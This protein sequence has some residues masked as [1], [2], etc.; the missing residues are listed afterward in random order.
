MGKY[1]LVLK[2]VRFISDNVGVV[3][4]VVEPGVIIL[5]ASM[6]AVSDGG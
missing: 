1:Y 6:V 3:A 2:V 4:S 5:S